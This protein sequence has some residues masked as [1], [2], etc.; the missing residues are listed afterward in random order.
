MRHSIAAKPVRTPC[1]HAD[2]HNRIF[3][4]GFTSLLHLFFLWYGCTH[5]Q[6]RGTLKWSVLPPSP[7]LRLNL[8][9][10]SS[11]GRR[12]TDSAVL[13]TQNPEKQDDIAVTMCSFTFCTATVP[14]ATYETCWTARTAFNR[15]GC[16]NSPA[17]RKIFQIG[18]IA[19][20]FLLRC[21]LYR[22]TVCG[23]KCRLLEAV[24]NRLIRPKA[25]QRQLVTERNIKKNQWPLDSFF[26]PNSSCFLAPETLEKVRL[27]ESKLCRI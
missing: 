23:E 13:F 3:Y 19:L 22:T 11:C 27:L 8:F 5:V 20:L 26:F 6:Q 15:S 4:I 16:Y 21:C 18:C 10:K 17:A 7:Q 14:G 24:W 1:P 9:S 12:G 2:Y 25:P